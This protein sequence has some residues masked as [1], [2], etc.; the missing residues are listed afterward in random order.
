VDCSAALGGKVAIN[1]DGHITLYIVCRMGLKQG[2]PLSSYL[3]ILADDCLNKVLSRD[4]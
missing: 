3:F 2:C 1:I 4:I